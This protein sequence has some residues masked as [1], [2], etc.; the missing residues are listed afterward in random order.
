MKALLLFLVVAVLLP[1]QV[2]QAGPTAPVSHSH[3]GRSHTHPLPSVGVG[4]RHG[5]GAP[6][7]VSGHSGAISN[8]PST[9]QVKQIA[10]PTIIS[11]NNTPQKLTKAKVNCRRNEPDCN[12]CAVN[13]QQQFSRAASGQ[14]HWQ[15]RYW[16]FKWNKQYPPNK[17]RPLEIFKGGKEFLL[18]IPTTHVQGF[19][20][21]NSGRFPYAGSHSHNRG[22][23]GGL[24]L[25]G[26]NKKLAM[27]MKSKSRHPSGVYA[28]GQ[29]L[30]YGESGRLFLKDLNKPHAKDS[31]IRLPGP[32]ANFGGGVGL[33]KL[34]DGS[35]LMLTTGPGGQDERRRFNRFY[36]LRGKNGR[37]SQIRYLGQSDQRKPAYWADG[38]KY[39]ENLSMIT[40]CGS[41]DIYVVHTT[42][43]QE[44]ISAIT[45]NA[46]PVV[47]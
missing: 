28:F 9:A 35:Y 41:G 46:C 14:I 29:Y 20:R 27:L 36:Q 1:S 25:V 45:G 5:H 33:V 21:T 30:V 42:G 31:S 24:F 34:Q 3:A 26:R 7:V 44:A 22:K 10:P 38:F 47:V 15:S 16:R 6:G 19:V 40:E 32:K 8:Y 12:V 2:I 11:P 13:V 37:M 23:Q 39:A 17:V 43:D 18:G 4:H